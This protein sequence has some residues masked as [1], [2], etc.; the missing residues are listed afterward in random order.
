MGRTQ[1]SITFAK[2]WRKL[3]FSSPASFVPGDPRKDRGEDQQQGDGQQ[4][5]RNGPLE[6]DEGV[7]KSMD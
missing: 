1:Q 5:Q 3:Y 4:D 7:P 2:P 6:H